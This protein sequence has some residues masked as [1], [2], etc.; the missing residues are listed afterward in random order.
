VFYFHGH[1]G[2]RLEALLSDTAAKRLGARIIAIDR[3][4]YGLSDSLPG[5]QILD[6]PP[7]VGEI[8]D[9]P[10]RSRAPSRIF[11]RTM[12]TSPSPSAASTIS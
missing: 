5:L 3:P 2:S 9:R 12:V 11:S 7:G 4:G 6:W 1:P 8:A 10:R